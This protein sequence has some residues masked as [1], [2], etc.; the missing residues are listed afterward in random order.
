MHPPDPSL[1]FLLV[2]M[3]TTAFIVVSASMIAERTGP[4]VAAMVA[5][6]PISA[7]PVYFFL[8]MEHGDAFIAEATLASMGANMATA[9]FSVA[10]VFA[11]QRLGTF[12][13]M[14]LAFLAHAPVLL[15]FRW[16]QPDFAAMLAA[17]VVAF[18]LAHLAVRPFLAVR[19]AVPA[20]R[21][22]HIIPLRAL[23]V[24]LLVATV[25]TLSH[26]IGGNWSGLF[27]TFP[28]VLST[29]IIFLQPRIGGPAMAAVIA[30]GL[31]GLMGFGGG[32]AVAHLA[33]GPL[34][35]WPALGLGLLACVAWN[36]ALAMWGRVQ[37]ARRISGD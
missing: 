8:A 35:R 7:G 20:S 4:L 2:K 33:A 32:L 11:A 18:P 3:L 24:A 37:P 29:L 36:L 31:L 28:V 22:W 13:A 25:T 1:T 19:S 14:A 23:F 34:G 21:A 5:T 6:L 15:F 12:G 10:Y 30:S 17:L 16:A 9:A 26:R 27:A